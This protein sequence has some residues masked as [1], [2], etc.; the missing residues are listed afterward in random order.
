MIRPEDAQFHAPT[1]D[2]PLWAETNYFGLYAGQDTDRPMNIGVY[3]L[4]REPLGVVGS[5]VSVNSRRVTMPWAADYWDAWEHLVAPASLLDYTLANG[6]HVVCSEPNKV[7]D[8]DYSDAAADL[9][10]HFR[11]TALMEPYDI[12]DPD[13]DPRA[14]GRDMDL[15]W[16]H[17][18]AGHFDQTGRFEGEIR[19]RGVT[20]PIDCV[21][22]MDHS[23]GVRAERQ[24]SRLSWMHAHVG[25]DLA[26]H[27][28]FD[29]DTANGPDGPSPLTMT[30]GYVLDNGVVRGLASGS[31]ETTRSGLYPE[32]IE[33]T[34]SDADG[35]TWEAVGDALTT[36]PWQSQP[37]VVGHNSLLRW[38]LDG[39]TAHGE[40][41]DFVGMGEL[42]RVYDR[43]HAA[44]A[45]TRA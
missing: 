2:D 29:F 33:I 38:T 7:W 31:G 10:L 26:L 44:A 6:L 24:T 19:L 45:G 17:A 36:F 43:V 9:E 34:V 40:C 21:S 15:T 37:G 13:Q 32:H 14:A 20:T 39:R 18:Y 35:R 28:L 5:T 27:A 41:M 22:T 25:P 8:V 3:G 42:G 11:Y 1:S 16:G 23:W 4:F 30:H 12:N